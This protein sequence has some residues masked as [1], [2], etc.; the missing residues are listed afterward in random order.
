MIFESESPFSSPIVVRKKNG[1][2]R[3]CIDYRKL[4]RPTVKNAYALLRMECISTFKALSGS[5]GFS[6][7]DLKSG[8]Y[9]IE[10][11]FVCPL[12]FWEFNCMPL[13][14]TNTPSTFQRL[15]G[16]C[17]GD[18]NLKEVVV[19]LDDLIVFCKTPEDHEADSPR[20]STV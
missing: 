1:Q 11:D 4:N 19:Y 13:G 12:G 10:V 14:V 5:N 2:V 6:V 8:H 3:L 20:F 7:L 15:M 9:Q 16:K 17:M 18:M